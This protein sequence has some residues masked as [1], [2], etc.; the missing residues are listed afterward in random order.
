M[1]LKFICENYPFNIF[2]LFFLNYEEMTVN[3]IKVC[4]VFFLFITENFHLLIKLP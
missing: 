4:V 1:Y 3:V 2:S